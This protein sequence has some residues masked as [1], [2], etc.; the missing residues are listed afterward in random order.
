M[1]YI[2]M[3][4]GT[5]VLVIMS[6]IINSRLAK[7]IGV[8]QGTLINYIV[9]FVCSLLVWLFVSSSESFDSALFGTVPVWA[10]FGGAV[11]VLIVVISNIVIP[12]I[13]TVYSTLIIFIGQLSTSIIIDYFAGKAITTGK[14]VGGLLILAG[15]LYNFMVDYRA[16]KQTES[17]AV[18]N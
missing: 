15:L 9:G 10:F 17:V 14:I 3:A 16:A 1:A 4:L 18:S 8:F 7:E 6:F 12:T 2:L 11:G 5:G 13:P